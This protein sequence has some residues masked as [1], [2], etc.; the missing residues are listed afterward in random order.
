LR[1]G[2]KR[3][4]RRIGA[5]MIACSEPILV[6]VDWISVRCDRARQKLVDGTCKD[7]ELAERRF[8][9]IYVKKRGGDASG[10]VRA[11][12]ARL[13]LLVNQSK[14]DWS[15]G[16]E[17]KVKRFASLVPRMCAR[18]TGVGVFFLFIASLLGTT[19][20]ASLQ[21]Q[22]TCHPRIHAHHYAYKNK[23][24]TTHSTNHVLLEIDE[25]PRT[26]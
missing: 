5:R 19:A 4:N 7:D 14:R 22:N 17:R 26:P 8:V 2:V 15:A 21:A 25:V 16:R 18:G 3:K 12:R 9:G 13:L 20:V 23:S 11:S 6:Y 10:V 24:T 1:H